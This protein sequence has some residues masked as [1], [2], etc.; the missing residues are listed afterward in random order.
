M[1]GAVPWVGVFGDKVGIFFWAV[2]LIGKD[3]K[4]YNPKTFLEHDAAVP[5]VET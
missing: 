2:T 3:G 5:S 1:G 4:I